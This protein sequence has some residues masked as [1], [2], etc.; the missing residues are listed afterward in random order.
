MGR[1][2]HSFVTLAGVPVHYDRLATGAYGTRGVPRREYA[3]ADFAAK[4][5]LCF[6]ELWQVGGL[7]RAEVIT[8]GGAYTA[9]PGRHGVG[10]AFDLD[11]IFWPDRVFVTLHAGAHGQDRALYF[12]IECLLRRHFGQVLDFQYDAAH[13]DHFHIDDAHP[14][15]FRAGSSATVLFAQG[16]LAHVFEAPLAADGAWGP[17]TAAALES[18]A[19]AL[20]VEPDFSQTSNWLTFLA[21]AAQLSFNK[22]R[23]QTPASLVATTQ[24]E[25][26]T[27]GEL[28]Q[29]AYRVIREELGDSAVRKT[30]ESALD[31]F[32]GHPEAHSLLASRTDVNRALQ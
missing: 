22:R 5:E 14:V 31:A 20:Q 8:T 29:T 6:H 28:F 12:G 23:G 26:L 1:P 25:P 18:A 16:L 11:G 24:T 9:K 3:E 4:L 10:R 7:G 17:V 15:G 2:V 21:R 30:I 32:A 27:P 13:R 19:R